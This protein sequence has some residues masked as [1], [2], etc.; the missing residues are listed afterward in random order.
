MTNDDNQYD[1]LV[2][3]AGI[4]GGETA[5]NLANLGHTVL[6][7]EKDLSV[8]GNMI[9]LSKVFPTLDCGACITTPKFSEIDRHKNITTLTSTEASNIVK[10]EDGSFSATI[11]TQPRYVNIEDCKSCP[12]C[13]EACPVDAIVETDIFEYHMTENH[14]RLQTKEMLLKLGEDYREKIVTKKEKDYLYK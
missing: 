3:G 11:T 14:Q 5:L 12:H 13:E 4:A 2:V 6:L 7:I 9:H 8:G 10:H 1:V